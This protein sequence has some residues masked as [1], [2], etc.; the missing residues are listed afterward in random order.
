MEFT[1]RF[2]GQQFIFSFCFLKT[3]R[4]D[5][6]RLYLLASVFRLLYYK[7][8]HIF[9]IFFKK[10]VDKSYIKDYNEIIEITYM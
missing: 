9:N 10:N 2:F 4:S 8:N 1:V 7:K 5:S 6:P 3:R